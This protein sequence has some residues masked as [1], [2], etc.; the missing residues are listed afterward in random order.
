MSEAVNF[1][2]ISTKALL[3]AVSHIGVLKAAVPPPLIR[4]VS[5]QQTSC[6]LEDSPTTSL[7]LVST[8]IYDNQ[9]WYLTSEWLLQ[10]D[11]TH[12]LMSLQAKLNGAFSRANPL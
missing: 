7:L 5:I 4:P 6:L 9:C 1:K 2:L 10:N 3:V 12:W 8:A 11:L